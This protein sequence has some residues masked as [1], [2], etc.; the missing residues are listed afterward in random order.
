MKNQAAHKVAAK[1][2]RTSAQVALNRLV[3]Q[4]V[5]AI[6]KVTGEVHLRENLDVFGFGL[7]GDDLKALLGV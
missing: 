4:G 7:D 6:P 3:R 5:A 2:G 1:N